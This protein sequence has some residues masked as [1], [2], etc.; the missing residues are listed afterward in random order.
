MW[1]LGLRASHN[2]HPRDIENDDDKNQSRRRQA[3]AFFSAAY[4]SS[5]ISYDYTFVNVAK[6]RNRKTQGDPNCNGNKKK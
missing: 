6:V 3:K 4:N 5:A 1:E 2:V